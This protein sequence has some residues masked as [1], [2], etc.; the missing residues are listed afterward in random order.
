MI[1]QSFNFTIEPWVLTKEQL[2]Y[3]TKI[4]KLFK[5]DMNLLSENHAA[6]FFTLEMPDWVNVIA[7]TPDNNIILV[8]QYRYGIEEPTLELPGGI[9]DNEE[10]GVEAAVRE[11]LEETGYKGDEVIDLGKISSNPAIQTNYTHS[12]VIKN[13]VKK[14]AQNLDEN[15]RIN[16]HVISLEEYFAMIANGIIHHSLVVASTAKY[17]LYTR[18]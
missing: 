4:F 5:R 15:E 18:K 17:L 7:L 14:A 8:E 11:L 6:T 3:T 16:I 10:T 9:V 1:K 12:I 2:E 13:C